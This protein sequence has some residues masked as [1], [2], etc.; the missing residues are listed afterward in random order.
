MLTQIDW[1]LVQ[2]IGTV[3]NPVL[4]LRADASPNVQAHGLNRK[5]CA[6]LS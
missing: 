3:A 5:Y 6:L 1:L 2:Q 4:F